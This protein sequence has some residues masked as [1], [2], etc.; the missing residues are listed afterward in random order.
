[1]A[2]KK[3]VELARQG[4]DAI[5]E[6]RAANKGV[7][8]ELSGVEFGEIDLSGADL[9]GAILIGCDL[10]GADLSGADLSR[11][12]L[13]KGIFR[14][15]NL[16]Q[17]N[18]ENATLIKT[19]LRCADLSEAS[20]INAN[21]SGADLSDAE[22]SGAALKET[23]FRNATGY[24]LSRNQK[25]E[26][27]VKVSQFKLGRGYWIL[28][29][30]FVLFLVPIAP[31]FLLPSTEAGPFEALLMLFFL[32]SSA[33]FFLGFL[34]GSVFIASDKGYSG[35]FGAFLFILFSVVAYFL[36]RQEV[37]RGIPGMADSGLIYILLLSWMGPIILV[38]LP[39]R[40]KKRLY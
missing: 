30:S 29:V 14:N 35:G 33:L 37:N 36:V 15:V 13:N 22:L 20:L 18:L 40:S 2:V 4:R 9:S 16:S 24:S 21:L 31:G 23:V 11:A 1:M 25:S 28:L 5:A 12:N 17:A 34:I 8:L 32:G 7:T 3:H 26:N 10:C 38:L 39:D 19:D 6:W 27:K